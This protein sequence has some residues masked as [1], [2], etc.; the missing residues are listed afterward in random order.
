MKFPRTQENQIF[1][2]LYIGQDYLFFKLMQFKCIAIVKIS[3]WET[4]F[5]E[6]IVVRYNNSILAIYFHTKDTNN[7]SGK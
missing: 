5:V 2:Q 4:I 6:W 7:S 3:L 1:I